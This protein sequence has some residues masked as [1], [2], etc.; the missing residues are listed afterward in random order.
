VEHDSLWLHASCHAGGSMKH[1]RLGSS[2]GR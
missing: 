1:A 2:P